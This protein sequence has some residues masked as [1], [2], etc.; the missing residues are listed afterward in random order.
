MKIKTGI[1][2]SLLT[3]SAAI[4]APEK[5][6][7]I[8]IIADDMGN[9]DAGFNGAKDIKTPNLDKLSETG[10]TFLQGYT[11]H[12]FCGPSRAGLLS[13]RYQH[14]F[15]FETNPAYD[16]SNLDMGCPKTERLIS[17]RIKP[18]GYKTGMIGKWHLGSSAN[19]HPNRRDFDYFYGFREGG[20]DYF[21]IDTIEGGTEHYLLPLEKNNK[22]AVFEGYLTD[23][24]TDE[25]CGFIER[26][27]DEPFFLYVGYNA[28]HSP[29]QAPEDEIAK[30]AH[31]KDPKRR[32]YAAMVDVMDQG[33]GKIVETLEKNGLRENTLIFFLS[34]NGGPISSA[35]NPHNGNGSQNGSWR[36]GKGDF[37]EGGLRVPMLA[38]WKGTLPAGLKYENP[39]ISLDLSRTIVELAGGEVN[40]PQMDGVN[41]FPFLMGEK[42][43]E[44]HKAL[45]W[46]GY[47]HTLW[48]VLYNGKKYV[49][50][51]WNKD[52]E[53]FDLKKD[54][55]ETT[56]IIS[57]N[58]ELAKEMKALWNEWDKPNI[59]YQFLEFYQYKV[60]QK[61]FHKNAMPAEAKKQLALQQKQNQK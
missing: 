10:V 45:F 7:M 5:P 32:V 52:P 18:S 54:P 19:A 13:G 40:A 37:Y 20:H 42:A 17:T 61:K 29:L 30:Y 33:I 8:I 16:P 35:E 6:N 55:R 34:D 36:G 15:G 51:K 12:P 2:A 14:R 59:P 48:S 46:R 39:V 49:K 43:G 58:P 21:K 53:M 57:Q 47:N 41:L 24:L 9:A 44:P 56:D 28:P 23:V 27:K 25:A 11:T 50:N 4:A 22:P 31:I 38:N 26:S 3:V 60:E 1:A